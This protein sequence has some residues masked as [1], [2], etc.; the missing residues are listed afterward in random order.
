MQ[1]D[2]KYAIAGPCKSADVRAI[3]VTRYLSNGQLD[4]SFAGTGVARLIP[5]VFIEEGVGNPT[6]KWA[7]FIQQDDK[8]IVANAGCGPVFGDFCL[9]RFNV[10]GSV[11]KF[12]SVT[13]SERNRFSAS[14]TMEIDVA[15]NG[16]I[17]VGGF[18]DGRVYLCALRFSPDLTID[19]STGV[20]GSPGLI[21]SILHGTRFIYKVIPRI[22]SDGRV[23]LASNCDVSGSRRVCVARHNADGSLDAAFAASGVFYSSVSTTEDTL[24]DLRLLQDGGVLI[25]GIASDPGADRIPISA[26]L[27]KLN[28]NGALDTNFVGSGASMFR[29]S[30]ADRYNS[31]DIQSDGKINALGECRNFGHGMCVTRHHANGSIDSSF[32]GGAGTEVFVA[33]RFDVGNAIQTQSDGKIVVAGQCSRFDATPGASPCMIRFTGGNFGNRHCTLDLDGDGRVTPTDTVIATRVSLGMKGNAVFQGLTLAS[34]ARRTTWGTNNDSDIRK[35]LTTQC[36]M[37]IVP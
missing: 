13:S 21:L 27:V 32:G 23:V 12:V 7:I 22:Q 19:T 16:Q 24:G 34:H 36:G 18:C 31:I 1:A 29:S 14:V 28:A 17:V 8:I 2:G 26:M 37:S 11:D 20:S 3:C 15:V 30:V 33:G 35:Y 10:N 25:S 9:T 4:T 5:P 6:D